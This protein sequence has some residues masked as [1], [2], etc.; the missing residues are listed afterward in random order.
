MI[1]YFR[2]EHFQWIFSTLLHKYTSLNMKCSLRCRSLKWLRVT[3]L[4][5]VFIFKIIKP[6]TN[7]LICHVVAMYW[8][9]NGVFCCKDF[10][11]PA[12]VNKESCP[13]YSYWI[14]VRKNMDSEGPPG[15]KLNKQFYNNWNFS[16]VPYYK[17][18]CLFKYHCRNDAQRR[19]YTSSLIV[20][21]FIFIC[22]C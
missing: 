11:L 9:H 18:S 2:K 12:P 6:C 19:N 13:R 16:K 5:I 4:W 7:E 20:R 17:R 8:Y 21:I 15:C 22:H 14:P 10:F 3:G 1:R